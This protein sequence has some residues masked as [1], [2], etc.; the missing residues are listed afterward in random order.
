MSKISNKS[1]KFLISYSYLFWGPLFIGTPCI[2]RFCDA[3]QVVVS[4][5]VHLPPASQNPFL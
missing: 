4:L 2:C 1:D 3:H 5:V